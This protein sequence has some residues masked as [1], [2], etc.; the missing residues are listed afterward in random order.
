MAVS[1][2]DQLIATQIAYADLDKAYYALR[3]G[4]NEVTLADA[5]V[6]AEKHGDSLSGFRNYIEE[7]TEDEKGN[8]ISVVFKKEYEHV[9]EWKL[10]HPVNDNTE[11]GTGFCACILDTGYDRILACRGSESMDNMMH[12]KQDWYEADLKLLNSEQTKQETALRQYMIDNS[13]L[14]MEKP[15]V[16]T[17]HSLG[18]AL[19]DHAAIVSVEEHIGNFSGAINFDGP[20]HSQE[21][22]KKHL[23]AL[24]QV[25]GKMIH[26]K[27]SIVGNLLFDLPGV[28]QDHIKTSNESR[29][30]DKYGNPISTIDG[31]AYHFLEHDTQYWVLDEN[32]NTVAGDQSEVEWAIEKLSRIIERLPP[33]IGNM[34]PEIVLY[35]VEGVAWISDMMENDPTLVKAISVAVIT[36]VL[37][38]PAVIPLSIGVVA[39]LVV[40]I[41]VVAIGLVVGEVIIETLE[42]IAEEIAQGICK[43]V[44]WLSDKATEL[45]EAITNAVN[46]ARQWFREK[47]NKGIAYVQN[48]PYFKADTTSLR[49]Y[50][51]RLDRVNNRLRNLDNNM[52]SLYWQVGLLDL[53]DILRANMITSKS[54]SLNQA[55]KYLYNTADRLENAEN[56]AKSYVGG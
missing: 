30:I 7:F 1:E 25:S 33:I 43:I 44:S 11:G 56:K 35:T 26:K 18:G 42:K 55:K 29:F 46:G 2:G 32:G 23:K 40:V 24:E 20:G 19:A 54:Y 48:N 50:A 13:D 36:F 12:F 28:A 47:T 9:G 17:G 38:N 27:A 45:F 14:L 37:N 5:I 6:Y 31:I 15:W 51:A 21:Y 39:E 41:A 16:A 34:L 49:E 4:G 10:I 22:I 3:K 53:W 8:I 52:R